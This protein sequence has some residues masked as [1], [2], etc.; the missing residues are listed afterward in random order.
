MDYTA[1]QKANIMMMDK[2]NRDHKKK[3]ELEDPEEI[4]NKPA[5]ILPIIDDVK[6]TKEI[7]A[8]NAARINDA[9]IRAADVELD[10][11]KNYT[12]AENDHNTNSTL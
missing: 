1:E 4:E 10:S 12:A 8:D 2:V 11:G 3:P 7:T 5:V 6:K 9:V